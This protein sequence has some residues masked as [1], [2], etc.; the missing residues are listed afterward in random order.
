SPARAATA[1]APQP[2]TSPVSREIKLIMD[3]KSSA[4]YYEMKESDFSKEKLF[5]SNVVYDT[6]YT[7]DSNK[8]IEY[9]EKMVKRFTV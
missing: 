4:I 2:P 3:P 7:S 6:L 5:Y 9:W 8:I 1:T